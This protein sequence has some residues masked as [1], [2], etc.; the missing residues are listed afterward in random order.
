MC[1]CV[2]AYVCVQ[3]VVSGRAGHGVGPGDVHPGQVSGGAGVH[4]AGQHHASS[5]VRSAAFP[6]CNRLACFCVRAFVV[7]CR[8]VA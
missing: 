2:H 3:R 6:G 1:V 8:S 4:P 7:K 5:Q